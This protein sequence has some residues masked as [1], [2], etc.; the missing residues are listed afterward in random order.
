M[1]PIP[2]A[3]TCDDASR[4]FCRMT[5]GC[6]CDV[7]IDTRVPVCYPTGNCE[8]CNSDAGCEAGQCCVIDS[9]N[10]CNSMFGIRI[11]TFADQYGQVPR[12]LIV[13]VSWPEFRDR[14][15]QSIWAAFICSIYLLLAW[16]N[17]TMLFVV[18]D[19]GFWS[20]WPIW[21]CWW[22][23]HKLCLVKYLCN[24]TTSLKYD[25]DR[26]HFTTRFWQAW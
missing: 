2:T 13:S 17:G 18:Y 4:E 22:P 25:R 9:T 15:L 20:L 23:L 6:G 14:G 26:M 12:W 24:S 10:R 7:T 3:T 19:Y 16:W 8:F 11:C 1:A 5:D 21:L